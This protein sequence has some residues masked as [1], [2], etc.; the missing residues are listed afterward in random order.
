[1]MIGVAQVIGMKADLEVL[2]FD[3]AALREHL[4]RGGKRKKLRDRGERGRGADR[5]EEGAARGILRKHRPHHRGGDD[6]LVPLVFDRRALQAWRGVPLMLDLAHMAAARATGAVQSVLRIERIIERRHR[7]APIVAAA[8]KAQR[9]SDDFAMAV[10]IHGGC[11]SGF[12]L[13]MCMQ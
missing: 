6:A 4:G 9:G 8:S 12:S 3:R 2:L 7:H 11:P 13:R 10:P 5:F 1:M